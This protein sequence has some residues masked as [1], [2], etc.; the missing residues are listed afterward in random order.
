MIYKS[1]IIGSC[2]IL[3]KTV[4]YFDQRPVHGSVNGD[5]INKIIGFHFDPC[6]HLLHQALDLVV[7]RFTVVAVFQMQLPRNIIDRVFHNSDS[8]D[9]RVLVQR[10]QHA[11]ILL[12]RR[13][14]IAQEGIV[15]HAAFR[16]SQLRQR[17]QKHFI[18][19]SICLDFPGQISLLRIL[20]RTLDQLGKP[21]LR[22]RF[23]SVYRYLLIVALRFVLRLRFLRMRSRRAPSRRAR[24]LRFVYRR[25]GA[26][27]Q[28]QQKQRRGKQRAHGAK[29][30]V[31]SSFHSTDL[32][33][34][35]L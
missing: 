4:Q 19:H 15:V 18:Y 12:A 21:L 2:I 26:R 34:A 7:C 11:E 5:Y 22:F 17:L 20:R 8:R 30:T 16:L 24:R 1:V 27:A 29:Y 31:R 13:H 23:F 14:V 9:R 28:A 35:V 6:P 33:C 25:V 10:L 32:L 3:L